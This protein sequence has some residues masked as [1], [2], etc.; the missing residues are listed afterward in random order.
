MILTII[1]GFSSIVVGCSLIAIFFL[2]RERRSR[3]AHEKIMLEIQ[4]DG[5]KR[6][7]KIYQDAWDDGNAAAR[8]SKFRGNS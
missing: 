3:L 7:M 1:I 2:A 5:A 8:E 6:M 4:E